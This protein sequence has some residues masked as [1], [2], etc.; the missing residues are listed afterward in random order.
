MKSKN[1]T[2]FFLLT[3]LISTQ[4]FSC[5]K[6]DSP[7]YNYENELKQ[8]DG[9]ALDYLK[10]QKGIYD[11]L[12]VV[13]SRLPNLEDSLR[14][15]KLTLFAVTNKSFQTSVENLNAV[16]KRTNKTPLYLATMDIK[17]L[18]TMTSRYIIRGQYTSKDF[19][20]YT[21]GLLLKSIG[22]NYSMHVLYSKADASG[23]IGGGPTV[24]TFSDPKN[25]IFIRY[26]Q[27]TPTNAVN[28]RTN[29]ATI[30]V[31]AP[32]HDFGFGDFVTR[33]NN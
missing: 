14:K 9:N 4:L 24:I 23:L 32:G 16:R 15:E 26:W 21:D 6:G 29:N 30:N 7:Y 8:F 12:L 11:S 20:N 1:R 22:Y 28:I 2:V 18:D 31:V 27:R 5:K 33:I 25:S 19:E 13:L 17:E 10:A 3:I